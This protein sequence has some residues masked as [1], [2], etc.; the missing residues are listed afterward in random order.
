MPCRPMNTELRQEAYISK[1]MHPRHK[2]LDEFNSAQLSCLNCMLEFEQYKIFHINV[3][4]IQ[5]NL[6]T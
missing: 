3:N 6:K 5:Q 4:N 2:C 1:I